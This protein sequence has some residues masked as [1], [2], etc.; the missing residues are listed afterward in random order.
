MPQEFLQNDRR[1]R[2][3][4]NPI[5]KWPLPIPLSRFPKGRTKMEEPNERAM[6]ARFGQIKTRRRERRTAL[7][8][9]IAKSKI[10][11]KATERLTTLPFRI[12]EVPREG[13]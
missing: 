13:K 10:C 5:R 7:F 11:G 1:E 3:F 2:G 9:L 6:H 12:N 4:Q 8:I